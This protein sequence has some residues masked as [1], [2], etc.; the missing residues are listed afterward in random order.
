VFG[1]SDRVVCGGH[2][3]E[4]GGVSGV[5]EVEERREVMANDRLYIVCQCG[6]R[7]ML[8]KFYPSS[9]YLGA[10]AQDFINEHSMKHARDICSPST[11]SLYWENTAAEITHSNVKK[12][13]CDLEHR[14]A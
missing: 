2:G 13:D 8:F 4:N 10:K 3:F 5:F 1:L 14:E 12:E 11:F 9:G 7:T 6:E